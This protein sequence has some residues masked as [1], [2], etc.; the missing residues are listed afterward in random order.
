[1]K[2]DQASACGK[3]ADATPPGVPWPAPCF[4]DLERE[5]AWARPF[6]LYT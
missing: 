3:F 1:M 4:L 5:A 2:V 6:R